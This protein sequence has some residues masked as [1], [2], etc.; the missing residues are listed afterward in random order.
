MGMLKSS[1]A[2]LVLGF[3]FFFCYVMSSGSY[4]Y[5][6]FVQQWPP[7]NCRVRMKRP[8]SNPRPLQY[9]TIHGLW[10]SNFSNPTKPS[11]C[12]GT[13]FDARKVYPEM[14]SDLKISWP[15]VE[16]GNDTKFW[17]DEWNKHGTCSEQTLNQF[18]YFERSHEMWMSYNI[19]EILKNASIVPHPA[20]TWTYSDIVS[21]IKAATGRTPLL[22]CKYDN[23]TQLLHEVV[24]CYGYKA[25]KQIDCNRPGCKN[26]IDI[27]F[28]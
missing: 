18:Q 1:L 12:N 15:D 7:T 3:A 14:R 27:K 8:C 9:F 28:Q 4:D 21:P 20:K 6:Q 19:T 5:F 13:K 10:P 2:F 11:N 23:N 26:K 24:F 25:I 17:E 16:S 22:R